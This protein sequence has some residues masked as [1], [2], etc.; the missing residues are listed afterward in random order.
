MKSRKAPLQNGWKDF[1]VGRVKGTLGALRDNACDR[2][3]CADRTLA[4]AAPLPF[5]LERTIVAGVC[6]VGEAVIGT[7]AGDVD[8]WKELVTVGCCCGC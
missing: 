5:V 8:F 2:F 7:G 6:K 4:G 1:S 3:E